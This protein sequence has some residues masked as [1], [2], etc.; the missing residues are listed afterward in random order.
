MEQLILPPTDRSMFYYVNDVLQAFDTVVES[1]TYTTLT[2]KDCS[3]TIPGVTLFLQRYE[4]VHTYFT[5]IDL[6]NTWLAYREF[7]SAN[8]AGV[9]FLDAHPAGS[10][11][12]IWTTLFGNI[13]R[14]QRLTAAKSCFESAV[15]V[16]AVYTS[17]LYAVKYLENA[18]VWADPKLMNEFVD[19]VLERFYL[20]ETRKVLVGSF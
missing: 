6:F 4:Y 14:A 2:S 18:A 16:P 10:L 3:A 1:A 12:E 20:Q 5:M 8:V 13:Q 15:L 17:Q 19:F 7:G 9:I 11:D